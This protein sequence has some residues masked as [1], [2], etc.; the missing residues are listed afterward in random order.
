MNY[1]SLMRDFW[2]FAFEN[3]EKIKPNHCA[4]FCYA[5]DLCNRLG[6]PVKFSLPSSMAMSATG[7]SS[8]NTYQ[9]AL[10]DLV[11]FGFLKM[12][13]KSK[14]QFTACVVACLNFKQPLVHALDKA[15]I[16]H[17]S[18]QSASSV[19]AT[20]AD[21]DTIN[22]PIYQSTNLPI[23]QYKEK[24]E[25]FISELKQSFSWIESIQRQNKIEEKDVL[26]F[27]EIFQLKLSAECDQK[28]NKNDFASH[29]ARWL[30]IELK[31]QKESGVIALNANQPQRKFFKG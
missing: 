1:Y 24:N 19:T 4:V 22:R 29:F 17:V 3:P 7:I 26:A 18:D 5:V 14:N 9:K 23:N 11:D 10:S 6:W 16:Q 27:L 13:E 25:K 2:D 28:N 21:T 20:M 15:I 30:P 12:I 31:K 8:R